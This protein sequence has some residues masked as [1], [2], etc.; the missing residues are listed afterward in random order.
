MK[1]LTKRRFAPVAFGA[2]LAI[3]ASIAFMETSS[4]QPPFKKDGQAKFGK[5]DG[6]PPFGKGDK[7]QPG[8][9]FPDQGDKK[10]GDR[11][12]DEKKGPVSDPVVDAWL[13]VLVE[14]VTD[15]HDT[16]RD[17]ARGAIVS[18]GHPAL[19]TLHRLADGEDPAKAVAA[20]K[21]IHAIEEHHGP[22]AQPDR[23]TFSGF[24]GPGFPG[25]P[26]MGNFGPQGKGPNR[27]GGKGGFGP[28]G[29][30]QRRDGDRDRDPKR[31][32]GEDAEE[33]HIAP[34][35]GIPGGAAPRK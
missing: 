33:T 6:Q 24:R 27:P 9:G 7:G 8:K 16:V 31:D 5:K 18:I 28:P 26:G 21:L 10:P 1:P 17:S 14:K 22:R 34:F 23:P 11:K 15:P 12:F 3:A 19:P 29:T 25:L 13:R 20:R 32:R 35:P 30:E 2:G 4:A